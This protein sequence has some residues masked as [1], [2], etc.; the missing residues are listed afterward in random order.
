VGLPRSRAC[1]EL[2]EIRFFDGGERN[3]SGSGRT[4]AVEAELLMSSIDSA[5]VDVAF[6]ESAKAERFIAEDEE[7]ASLPRANKFGLKLG[8]AARGMKGFLQSDATSWPLTS[9]SSRQAFLGFALG[10]R[11]ERR[12][13]SRLVVS[14]ATGFSD[15]SG[16]RDGARLA[17][18]LRLPRPLLR[19]PQKKG[20]NSPDL[21]LKTRSMSRPLTE[22]S[23]QRLQ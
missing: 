8:E 12:A 22:V 6:N 18:G 9:L 20:E 16:A 1:G 13:L 15:V 7:L 2:T 19:L 3:G 11:L 10:L 23:F 4:A 17:C 21:R 5:T 14:G